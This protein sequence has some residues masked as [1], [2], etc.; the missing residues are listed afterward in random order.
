MGLHTR[1]RKRG[2]MSLLDGKFDESRLPKGVR[3]V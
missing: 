1:I 2:N 3:S